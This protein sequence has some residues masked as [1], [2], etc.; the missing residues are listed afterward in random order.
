ME[1][2]VKNF[3]NLIRA[4][5]ASSNEPHH[6]LLPF[7]QL[8]HNQHPC[9]LLANLSPEDVLNGSTLRKD[10]LESYE[11]YNNLEDYYKAFKTHLDD[12]Q[13]RHR[14]KK[15]RTSGES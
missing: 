13:T 5:T 1:L 10:L 9:S 2:Q 7:I 15:D 11:D 3:K 8:A 12:I 4:Y 14:E 6:K